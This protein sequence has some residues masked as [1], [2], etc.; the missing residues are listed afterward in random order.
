LIG[1][2]NQ[3]QGDNKILRYEVQHVEKITVRG[4]QKKTARDG[5][6]G[7]GTRDIKGEVP[8]ERGLQTP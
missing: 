5:D 6:W 1:R 7:S 8:A 3:E 4:V 2:K